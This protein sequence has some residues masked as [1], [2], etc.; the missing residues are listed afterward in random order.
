MS[1]LKKLFG[2]GNEPASGEP[3]VLGEEHHLD[4]VIK[5]TEMKVGSEYQLSGIIEKEIDGELKSS[6]FIRA[7]RLG[8]PEM[9]KSAAIDKA[10]QIIKE[11]GDSLFG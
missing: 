8:S 1:F 10:K 3:K 11:Q 4:Y 9:A 7:D 5:A 2:M 6:T